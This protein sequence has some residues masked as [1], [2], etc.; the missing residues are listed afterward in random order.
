MGYLLA[1]L[2]MLIPTVLRDFVYDVVAAFR[3]R[4]M[5]T[6]DICRSNSAPDLD[7]RFIVW[8]KNGYS[9]YVN[10]IM[11]RVILTTV[12]YLYESKLGLG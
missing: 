5:G 4:I 9:F 11:H 2:G 1:T 8:D 10:R 12:L 6:R 3:Y 7:Q